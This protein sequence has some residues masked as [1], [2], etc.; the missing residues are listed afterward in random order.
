MPKIHS[1]YPLEWGLR[2]EYDHSKQFK[3]VI[4][5]KQQMRNVKKKKKAHPNKLNKG[6]SSRMVVIPK[7]PQPVNLNKSWSETRFAVA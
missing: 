6:N 4:F 2:N 1:L 5:Y 7:Q 3:L